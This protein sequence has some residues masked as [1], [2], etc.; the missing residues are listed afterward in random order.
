[1]VA[2]R[3][4]RYRGLKQNIG[5]VSVLP[6]HDAEWFYLFDDGLVEVFL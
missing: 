1:M 5:M 6:F 3:L 2:R 4:L